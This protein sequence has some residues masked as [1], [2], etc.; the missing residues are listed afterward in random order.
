MKK[1]VGVVGVLVLIVIGF[2]A[3]NIGMV[4]TMV[5]KLMPW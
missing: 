4:R 3:I 2:S 1:V 5:L